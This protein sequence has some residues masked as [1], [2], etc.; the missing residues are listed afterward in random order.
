MRYLCIWLAGMS[1]LLISGCT[2]QVSSNTLD[3]QAS[4][5]SLL[6][7][8]IIYNL[9]Q[10]RKDDNFFPS[11]AVVT[12]GSAQTTNTIT[13]SLTVPLPTTTI[14]NAVQTAATPTATNTSATAFANAGLGV[15]FAD[16]W[17]FVWSLDMVVDPDTLRRLR[18]LYRFAAG[19]GKPSDLEHDYV[20]QGD[21]DDPTNSF[22]K[23]PGCVLCA[24]F[25]TDRAGKI[26]VDAKGKGT[27]ISIKRNEALTFNLV[28]GYY[29]NAGF[30]KPLMYGDSSLYV[31]DYSQFNEFV[32]FVLESVSKS[33]TTAKAK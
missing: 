6:M 31:A 16:S 21:P 30:D 5:K 3:M 25:E 14:T 4:Y 29:P 32:L 18:A 28:D 22:I 15:T 10:A 11:Q 20:L 23:K 17:Q 33:A 9:I 1:V 26:I 7:K 24:T 27:V 2:A 13:P 12:T 8:Q 19:K